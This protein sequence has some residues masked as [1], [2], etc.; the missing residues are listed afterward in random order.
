MDRSVVVLLGIAIVVMFALLVAA[1]AGMLARLD[2]AGYPT[3]VVRA[4]TAFAAVLT[5][6]AVVATAMAQLV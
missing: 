4:A 1:A 6:A 2:G 3:A 5:L